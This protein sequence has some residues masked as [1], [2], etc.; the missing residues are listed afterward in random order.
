MP[1]PGHA[2]V[3]TTRLYLHLADDWLAGEYRRASEAIDHGMGCAGGKAP[4]GRTRWCD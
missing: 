1:S 3:E 4:T 2:S